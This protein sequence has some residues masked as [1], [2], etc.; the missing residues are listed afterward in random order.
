MSSEVQ[1]SLQHFL[2]SLYRDLLQIRH[3]VITQA[4]QRIDTHPEFFNHGPASDSAWNLACYIAFREHDMRALQQRLAAAGMSSLG[5]GEA[6][7]M[8]NLD[9]VIEVLA[10]ACHNR[11]PDDFQSCSLEAFERGRRYLHDHTDRLFG[12]SSRR[13]HTRIMVTLPT[14]AA[15]N[16]HLVEDILANGA[17]CLRINC[18]HDN[19]TLWH[20]MINHVRLVCLENNYTCKIMM[21]LAG[22]KIRTREVKLN[23]NNNSKRVHKGDKIFLTYDRDIESIASGT[24][25][26]D[27]YQA[28]I[29]CSQP[30]V[31]RQLTTGQNVWFDDGKMGSEIIAV[32]ENGV[33]LRISDVGAR[34]MKLKADKGLNFPETTLQLPTL[35]DK[36]LQDLDFIVQHADMVAL[37]FVQKPQDMDILMDALSARGHKDLPIIAKIETRT[38]VANL[39]SILLSTIDR[40]P[41]GIMI[42]RGD[43]AVELGSVRM[44][45]IQEEILWLSEAAHT[46]VIW[47]TQILEYLAKKGRTSR[48]EITDA[49]MSVRAECVMLNKGPY[50]ADAVHLLSDILCR[51]ESHQYKKSSLLRALHLH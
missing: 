48:P 40:H 28:C 49:A 31:I 50:I 45:E 14:E 3:Q 27:S 17:E 38:G 11:L 29:S 1:E 2:Q 10:L 5:R 26:N 47:A 51:M 42:A 30:E 44:A 24:L 35:T 43:L 15:E 6:H 16:I 18:A 9:R 22:H 23:T 4:R 37:S 34:G 20:Q 21:D 33:I 32:E 7:I 13:H 25:Q 39:A 8:A 41:V 36:D 12:T 46:P 19:A